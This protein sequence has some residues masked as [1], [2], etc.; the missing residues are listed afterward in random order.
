MGREL[1]RQQCVQA[2]VRKDLGVRVPRPSPLEGM[3]S[4]ETPL[5][6]VKH[7]S[8][9]LRTHMRLSRGSAGWN[10]YLAGPSPEAVYICEQTSQ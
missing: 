5:Y 7:Q 3:G 1:N 8:H 6:L 2:I 4:C 9:T 10:N